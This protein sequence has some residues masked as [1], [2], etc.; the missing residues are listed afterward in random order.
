MIKPW[1]TEIST[2]A[3]GCS[4]AH[5]QHLA[6]HHVWNPTAVNHEN[7]AQGRLCMISTAKIGRNAVGISS[8][9]KGSLFWA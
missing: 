4:L 9:G 1:P 5:L 2:R 7:I 3:K 6:D 8:D